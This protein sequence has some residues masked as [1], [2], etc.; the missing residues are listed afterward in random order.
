MTTNLEY[1]RIESYIK[2]IEDLG[3]VI[4]KE[5]DNVWFAE[6]ND[7]QK[8]KIASYYEDL[9][10]KTEE[11]KN[12]LVARPIY[13]QL[14]YLKE[15]FK[16]HKNQILTKK[17]FSKGEFTAYLNNLEDMN[18]ALNDIKSNILFKIEEFMRKT[19]SLLIQGISKLIEILKK[20]FKPLIK[21]FEELLKF[22]G[23]IITGANI[24]LQ[25]LPFIIIGT[26]VGVGWVIYKVIKQPEK[27]EKLVEKLSA[28]GVKYKT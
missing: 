25:A 8:Q 6:L 26:I 16:F 2:Y 14:E 3:N 15:Q 10:N 1:A 13:S 24:L 28:F 21:T 22:P 9:I 12:Y 23:T 11:L 4:F 5:E 20:I 27:Y 7:S 18:K 19:L 17:K